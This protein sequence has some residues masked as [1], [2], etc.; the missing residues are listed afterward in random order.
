MTKRWI[1]PISLEIISIFTAICKVRFS[2]EQIEHLH[3]ILE[4]RSHSY[5]IHATLVSSYVLSIKF[6]CEMSK[7][8]QI[9][10]PLLPTIRSIQKTSKKRKNCESSSSNSFI[11]YLVL[12]LL[13]T[14]IS[15]LGVFF[16]NKN[17]GKENDKQ[18]SPDRFSRRVTKS[19]N[20]EFFISLINHKRSNTNT[21]CKY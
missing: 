4:F 9:V 16:N 1:S 7:H 18:F 3:C 20:F 15:G 14:W 8:H 11:L 17:N 6:S 21:K 10:I 5:Q 12:I 13:L 19:Q 2:Y